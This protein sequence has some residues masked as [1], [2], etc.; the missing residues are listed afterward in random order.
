MSKVIALILLGSLAGAAS[1][2]AAG[3]S[4]W[5]GTPAQPLREGRWIYQ[6]FRT[7][8]GRG[9]DRIIRIERREGGLTIAFRRVAHGRAGTPPKESPEEGPFPVSAADHVLEYQ[10]PNGP[11]RQTYRF[12]GA[13][14][15]T[16]AVVATDDRTWMSFQSAVGGKPDEVFTKTSVWQC[17]HDPRKVPEG[18]ARFSTTNRRPGDP[19]V[20]EI[21]GQSYRYAT[22]KDFRGRTV[23]ELRFFQEFTNAPPPVLKQR[24]ML[25]WEDTADLSLGTTGPGIG[26]Q[27]VYKPAED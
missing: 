21:P 3:P 22:R 26:D 23:T 10:G 24:D 15:V 27:V 8:D 18:P 6:S 19:P 17:E 12:D 5:K 7:V 2:R 9:S 4:D 20:R 1:S 11:V 16:P 13:A 14:L 25:Y